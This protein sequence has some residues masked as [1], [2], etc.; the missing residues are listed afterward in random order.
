MRKCQ[1]RA[2]WTTRMNSS[3]RKKHSRRVLQVQTPEIQQQI[4]SLLGCQ[5]HLTPSPLTVVALFG[6]G[7]KGFSL[8][9]PSTRLGVAQRSKIPALHRG[10][11]RHFQ[12]ASQG[13]DKSGSSQ[14]TI[15]DQNSA[16]GSGCFGRPSGAAQH[17]NFR[18]S[19]EEEFDIVLQPETRPI[20]QE[21]LGRSQGPL[22]A[23]CI[24]VDD[25]QA[26]LG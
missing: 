15:T 11:Q 8:N 20:S 24:K 12:S 26:T 23:K 9:R 13:L 21:Q 6:R 22:E 10:R 4:P 19:L 17:L 25:K 1:W 16:H 5:I 7:N 3:D 14:R 2:C 18:T